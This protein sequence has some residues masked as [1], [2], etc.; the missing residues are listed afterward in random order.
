V[1]QNLA[2]K[3]HRSCRRFVASATIDLAN[4]EGGHEPTDHPGEQR[5]GNQGHGEADD[6]SNDLQ[7]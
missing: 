6:E 7:G 2:N 5:H 1:P 4:L 3:G